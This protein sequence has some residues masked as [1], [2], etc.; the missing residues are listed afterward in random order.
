[1]GLGKFLKVAAFCSITLGISIQCAFAQKTYF[2]DG[3]HG[4]VWGH[5]PEWYTQFIV[6]TLKKNPNWKINFEIEPETWPWVK[7]LQPEA[8][9]ELQTLF[10]DSSSNARVEYVNPAYGQSYLYNTSGE[11]IIR[12]FSYGIDM[13]KESFPEVKFTT[14]SAEEPCFT[15]ALPQILKSFG[16][17]Y[18]SLKNPNTCWGG[19]TRAFGGELVNWIGPDGT[20]LPTV[21]RYATETLVPGSTWQTIAW[22]NSAEYINSAL[23]FGIKNPVGM[24]LQDAGWKNGPW[25]GANGGRFNSEYKLWTDY[26]ENFSIGKAT[27]NWKFSQEDVQVS[28]VWGAQILQKLAQQVRVSENKMVA[29]EKL[30]AMASVYG[31][32]PWPKSGLDEGWRNLLLAQHHDCWIVPYNGGNNS[33]AHKVARWTD[34]SNSKCDSVFTASLLKLSAGDVDEN[35]YV[36]VF[37]T[38]GTSRNN[39]TSVE[40]PADF[41]KQVVVKEFKGKPVMSQIVSLPNGRKELVFKASVPS[42]GYNTYKLEKSASPLKKGASVLKE[43]DLYRIETDYYSIVIDPEKGGVI[44]SLVAKKLGNKEFVDRSN[45]R[46]FNELRGNFYRDGGYYSST[47]QPAKV[48]IKENGPLR[49]V[50]EIS[51]K[52]N[53]HPFFQILTLAQGEERI[54]LKVKIDWQGNP[55]IGNEYAQNARWRREDLVKAFYSDREKLSVLFP[56][57]LQK[58]QVYKDA[59]FDVTESQLKNTFF[60]RWDSIKNN[61]IL[62]WVDIYDETEGYGMAMFTDHTTSY[63]HGENDPLGLTLQYSGK[64]LWGR[65]YKIEG[66]TEVNYSLMPHKGKWDK[67]MVWTEGTKINE[68]LITSLMHTPPDQRNYKR[69]LLKV[70]NTGWEISSIVKEKDCLLIR[71]FNAEGT[72]AKNKIIVDIPLKTAELVELNGELKEHLAVTRNGNRSSLAFAIPKFGIRTI[73]VTY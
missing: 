8:F 52:I 36:R 18:A 10:K 27:S 23:A 24:C 55:G 60:T 28:L 64:G 5:Y 67:S 56:V 57:N 62:N 31:N 38:S 53:Q 6:E 72:N 41:D 70:D 32:A 71:V 68:P 43:K 40:L 47:S 16:F 49:I 73:K 37:N 29:A 39:Y 12:Q 9:K 45:S 20:K 4:G 51:G 44:K 33:W 21:P 54:D 50:L 17:K 22:T 1:L 7:K 26:I 61:V 35:T 3:Y 2:I 25:L 34:L 14:Y 48:K 66:P 58:Q 65:N 59:P 42:V 30:A 15:S 13:I 69:S 46:G 63:S 19:Y 11:S